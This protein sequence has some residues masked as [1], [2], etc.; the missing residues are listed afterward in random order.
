MQNAL[1]MPQDLLKIEELDSSLYT[2]DLKDL[3]FIYENYL[4][5]V[6]S[7]GKNSYKDFFTSALDNIAQNKYLSEF[8][9]I[10]FYGIY[11]F[12]A[13]QYDI[14]KEISHNY[15]TTI[16][17]PYEDI[18]AYKYIKDFYLSSIFGL[19]LKHKEALLPGRTSFFPWRSV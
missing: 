8:K 6:R 19:G 9:Q 3:I 14:L 15:P 17:F 10:I 1:I 5:L 12:T 13:L 2:Q 16:F 11:D 4:D 18:P 7:D